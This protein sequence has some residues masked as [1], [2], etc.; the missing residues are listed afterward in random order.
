[1]MKYDRLDQVAAV[2]RDV[3]VALD[4]FSRE[5]SDVQLAAVRGVQVDGLTRTFDVFFDNIFSDLAALES[6]REQVLGG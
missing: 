4:R 5:L 6:R 3:D 2:L 1:M